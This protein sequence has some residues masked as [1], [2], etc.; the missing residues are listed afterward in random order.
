MKTQ[1]DV[2]MNVINELTRFGR[3]TYEKINNRFEVWRNNDNKVVVTRRNYN[4]YD[5]DDNNLY[6]LS[7]CDP[8]TGNI[9]STLES[10]SDDENKIYKYDENNRVILV[11]SSFE[12]IRYERYENGN[13]KS[14]Y[15]IN[16]DGNETIFNYD[17][18]KRCISIKNR[19]NRD[20]EWI[21]VDIIE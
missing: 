17:E 8:Y 6:Q 16:S 19:S 1:Y 14:Q 20:S 18:N 2:M 15:T 4:D 7:T 9:L 5:L 13:I 10:D 12:E 11:R 21:P 3:L